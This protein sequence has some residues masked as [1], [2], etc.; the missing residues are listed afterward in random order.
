M[1]K[2]FLQPAGKLRHRI[3]LWSPSNTRDTYGG[4][5]PTFTEVIKLWGA[6]EYITGREQGVGD[7][8]KN[9]ADVNITIRYYA[10]LRVDWQL[11]NDGNIYH[12]ENIKNILE[13]NK[14]MIILCRRE[15]AAT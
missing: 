11:R 5:E 6:I 3:S 1:T 10:D 4:F 8:I 12:I 9:R 2:A 15:L 14:K 7:Q 13:T